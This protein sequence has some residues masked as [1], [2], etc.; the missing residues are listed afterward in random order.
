MSST[1]SC[2]CL[3]CPPLETGCAMD[4]SGQPFSY[5]NTVPHAHTVIETRDEVSKYQALFDMK[6]GV[7]GIIS[8]LPVRLSGEVQ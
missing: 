8:Q 7:P 5:E 2:N 4:V 1:G 6:L 3:P